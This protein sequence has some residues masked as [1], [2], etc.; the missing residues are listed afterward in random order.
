MVDT[1]SRERKGKL[2]GSYNIAPTLLPTKRM[3][4]VTL[5]AP[6]LPR[7]PGAEAGHYTEWV[8]ACMLGIW[9]ETIEF[10]V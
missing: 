10:S 3:T 1:S 9:K 7:V 2:A 8:E 5:P 6:T 4:E